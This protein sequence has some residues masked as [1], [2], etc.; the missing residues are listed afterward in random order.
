MLTLPAQKVSPCPEEN[1]RF[2]N[3]YD[4]SPPLEDNERFDDHF[5]LALP[6]KQG[7]KPSP[8]D[9]GAASTSTQKSNSRYIR[10]PS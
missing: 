2:D 1:E 7:R 6:G 10:I 4:L 5:N 8:V 3:H 9:T